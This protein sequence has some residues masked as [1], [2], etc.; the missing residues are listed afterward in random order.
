MPKQKCLNCGKWESR[1]FPVNTDMM[2][3]KENVAN[4]TGKDT[5]KVRNNCHQKTSKERLSV[6]SQVPSELGTSDDLVNK[7]VKRVDIP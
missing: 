3:N 5:S 1:L 6:D 2:K 7:R 4:I